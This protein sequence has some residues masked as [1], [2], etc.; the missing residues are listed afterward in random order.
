MDASA[1]ETP[2]LDLPSPLSLLPLELEYA[3]IGWL[4]DDRPAVTYCFLVCRRWRAIGQSILFHEVKIRETVVKVFPQLL[5]L[6]RA[7]LHAHIAGYIHVLRLEDL[8][9]RSL[10]F[11]MLRI[12]VEAMVHLHTLHLKLLT[13][14]FDTPTPAAA[15][16]GSYVAP[17]TYRRAFLK[18]LA[19]IYCD[20]SSSTHNISDLL[21]I[22]CM[23][24]EID[25]L[26]IKGE[27]WT[28]LSDISLHLEH[29]PMVRSLKLYNLDAACVSA[30]HRMVRVSR[31]LD[32]PM[33]Y[34][35]I[36]AGTLPE[37]IAVT[38]LVR[39]VGPQLHTLKLR[40]RYTKWSPVSAHGEYNVSHL[41][42]PKV[43]MCVSED[44]LTS[45]TQMFVMH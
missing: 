33:T 1:V 19:I 12:A 6:V 39:E 7:S 38:D 31:S 40:L 4:Q 17:L 25:H 14:H 34:L 23:F 30:I 18:K 43:R 41:N 27:D 15:L 10:S 13:L 21:S 45:R 44:G 28:T 26:V 9:A 2:N 11:D 5:H 16:P 36:C 35:G 8:S 20:T 3:I 29:A 37:A 24:A 42:C 22:I 32:G